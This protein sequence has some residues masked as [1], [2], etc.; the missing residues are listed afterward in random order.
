MERRNLEYW[1]MTVEDIIHDLDAKIREYDNLSMLA[2]LQENTLDILLRREF[3]QIE[4]IEACSWMEQQLGIKLFLNQSIPISFQILGNNGFYYSSDG[5][6]FQEDIMPLIGQIEKT[7][8]I[9][10]IIDDAEGKQTEKKNVIIGRYIYSYK[11]LQPL[12]YLLLSLPSVELDK[13]WSDKDLSDIKILVLN[14]NGTVVYG[15]AEAGS[16]Q[17]EL[18]ESLTEEA[19]IFQGQR[20]GDR[21]LYIYEKSDYTGWT[22]VAIVPRSVYHPSIWNISKVF[23]GAGAIVILLA[24]GGAYFLIKDVYDTKLSNQMNE[25]ARSKAEMKALQTQINP[26]FLYNT[27][28]AINMYS[29]LEDTETVQD[30]T[31]ALSSMFRYAVQNPLVP[32]GIEEELEHVRNYL[33]IQGY[34]MGGIPRLE[35]DIAG[36]E[37]VVML[38]LSLQPIVENIFKHAFTDGVG[39]EQFIRIHAYRDGENLLVDVEDN[40]RGPS[41]EV[42]H[43]EYVTDGE[44]NGRGIGLS[45]VHKRLKLAYGEGAGL[46]ISGRPGKGMTIQICQPYL[47]KETEE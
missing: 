33:R 41:M 34:R 47:V 36:T 4:Y 38:R 19:G 37:N 18:Y 25:I 20:K 30:I 35:I 7:G 46:W 8:R 43:M 39:G 24:S 3:D 32:V 45:N 17:K 21:K 9:S 12:G 10:I 5:E 28:S 26:H 23:L 27:L 22:A 40:G 14:E 29:V 11:S 15:E 13:I 31:D 1:Q 16:E 6:I 2:L 44:Q 42:D